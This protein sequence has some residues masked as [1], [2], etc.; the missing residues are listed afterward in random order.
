MSTT[1]ATAA[2]AATCTGSIYVL[3]IQDAACALPN[4]GNFSSIMDKCCTPASVTKYNND[5]G[6]YCLA[7]GQTVKELLGCLQDNGAVTQAFCSANLNASATASAST[8]SATGKDSKTGTATGSAASASSTEKGAGVVEK[9]VSLGG[10]VV[11][12]MMVVYGVGLGL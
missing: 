4:T 6:L 1:T 5:C 2:A 9:K 10:W 3:P 7:Q 8:S 12:G 11:L